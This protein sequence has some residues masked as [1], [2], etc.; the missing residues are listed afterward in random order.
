MQ[1]TIDAKLI[2]AAMACQAKNDVRYYLTGILIAKNGDVVGCDGHALFRGTH[3]WTENDSVI[4]DD[5]IISINGTIPVKAESVTFNIGDNIPTA[6]TDNGKMFTC[7]VLEGKYPD[8]NKVIPSKD[9]DQY[10]TVLNF[11][12]SLLAK[13][14]KVFGKDAPIALHHRG[15]NN[16]ILI[17]CAKMPE[18]CLVIMPMKGVVTGEPLFIKTSVNAKQLAA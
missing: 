12:A 16:S 2:R 8:Y 14:E 10:S 6:S 13:A 7:E 1:F 4:G 9:S 15:P 5:F 17:E 18:T 3:A 11:N